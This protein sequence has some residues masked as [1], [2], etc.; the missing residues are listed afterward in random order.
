MI[1]SIRIFIVAWQSGLPFL[2]ALMFLKLLSD[3]IRKKK[4]CIRKSIVFLTMFTLVSDYH[5]QNPIV[6]YVKLAH[7][8]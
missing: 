3:M 5:F 8:F 4:K 1:S 2:G 7:H 6:T